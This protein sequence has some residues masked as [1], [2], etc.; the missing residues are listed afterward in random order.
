MRCPIRPM[1]LVIFAGGGMGAA[2]TDKLMEQFQ[3]ALGEGPMCWKDKCAA[4][5]GKCLLIER[6]EHELDKSKI[7]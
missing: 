5:K 2:Q 3:E 1:P 6:G 4:W 7:K